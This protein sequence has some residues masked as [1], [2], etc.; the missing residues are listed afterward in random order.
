MLPVQ[1]PDP[2]I[3][4]NVLKQEMHLWKDRILEIIKEMP[5]ASEVEISWKLIEEMAVKG[6]EILKPVFDETKGKKR[7]N[8]HS[9]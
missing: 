7:E 2:V 9:D 1:Q 6:A 3:V 4:L 8:I 5:T